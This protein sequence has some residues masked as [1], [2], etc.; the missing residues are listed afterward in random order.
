MLVLVDFDVVIK[1]KEIISSQ[2]KN[3]IKWYLAAIKYHH[4]IK[5]CHFVRY[6][7]IVT[8]T[9][10]H[11]IFWWLSKINARIICTPTKKKKNSISILT[12][13]ILGK[14]CQL[15]KNC[16]NFTISSIFIHSYMKW[17]QVGRDILSFLYVHTL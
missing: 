13:K 4:N 8:W 12:R 9:L 10:S 16:D 17:G 7:G 15:F 5:Y 1:I 3:Y 11:F 14:F 6:S 2:K